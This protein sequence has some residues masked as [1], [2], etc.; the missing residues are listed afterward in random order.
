MKMLRFILWFEFQFQPS[1]KKE[2]YCFS[3]FFV[4]CS[5][6]EVRYC[7]DK[8][9]NVMIKEYSERILDEKVKEQAQF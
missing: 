8:L 7:K 6:V 1:A 9:V 3:S 5:S 2:I 4:A